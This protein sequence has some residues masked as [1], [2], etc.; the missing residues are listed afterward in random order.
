MD[1]E[2]AQEHILESF[3]EARPGD[4]QAMVDAHV[5]RCAACT[6]F[7]AKQRALDLGLTARLAPPAMSPRFR[8]R[9]RERI[10]HDT[11]PAWPDLLPDAVHFASCGVATLVSLAVLPISAPVV[12]AIALAGTFL[13]HV[14]LTAAHDSLDGAEEAGS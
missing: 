13:S 11:R 6:A 9:L 5:A 1:C 14:V 4:V 8:A 10:R 12:L 2:H 3:L 7:A